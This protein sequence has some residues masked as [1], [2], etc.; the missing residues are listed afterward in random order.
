MIRTWVSTLNVI[1][2][3]INSLFCSNRAL[4]RCRTI[5]NERGESRRSNLARRVSSSSHHHPDTL[6][7]PSTTPQTPRK[8]GPAPPRSPGTP[9]RRK[10]QAAKRLQGIKPD[11]YTLAQITKNLVEKL[12]LSFQPD[13]WQI[14]LIS[15]I[16]Q[17]YDSIFC[18]GTG[19]SSAIPCAHGS[20]M[21]CKCSRACGHLLCHNW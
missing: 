2:H 10:R 7:M 16:R 13:E 20:I 11:R 17:G 14:Q 15:K 19:S 18:A 6:G 21:A 9:R 3:L 8:L 4:P 12:G 5:E 1:L